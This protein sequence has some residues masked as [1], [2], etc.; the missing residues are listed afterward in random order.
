MDD[1]LYGDLDMTSGQGPKI[2]LID[3]GN[4]SIQLP[5][6]VYT[7]VLHSLMKLNDGDLMFSVDHDDDNNQIMKANK[8]C[9]Q[10]VDLLKPISFKL[11][12]TQITI[13]PKGYTYMIDVS[14]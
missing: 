5:E 8:P 7:N 14:Q 1:F 6:F 12:N 9:D 4:T 11:E 13:N 3:S 2:A 10:V